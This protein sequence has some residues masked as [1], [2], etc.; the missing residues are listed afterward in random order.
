MREDGG[1]FK[2]GLMKW[3]ACSFKHSLIAAQ[4][5][6]FTLGNSNLPVKKFW[7]IIMDASQSISWEE[8]QQLIQEMS[9]SLLKQVSEQ[10]I[11]F[12]LILPL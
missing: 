4:K 9:E 6:R 5:G 3:Q 7:K 2:G 11:P 8:I 12:T 10:S 1:C